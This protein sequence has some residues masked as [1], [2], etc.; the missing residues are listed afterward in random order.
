[1]TVRW[2]LAATEIAPPSPGTAV[3]LLPGP[4][5][6]GRS[7]EAALPTGARI[8]AGFLVAD[9]VTPGGPRVYALTADGAIARVDPPD[10]GDLGHQ[11]RFRPARRVQVT[12]VDEGGTPV[13][14]AVVGLRGGGY[15]EMV[16]PTPTDANGE[17]RFERLFPALLSITLIPPGESSRYARGNEVQSVNLEDGDADVTITHGPPTLERFEFHLH[18]DGRP[19]LPAVLGLSGRGSPKVVEERP[20]GRRARRRLQHARGRHA[21]AR[22]PAPAGLPARHGG[23]ERGGRNGRPQ[24]ARRPRARGAAARAHRRRGRRQR[25]AQ[26]G[27]LRRG[28]TGVAHALRAADPSRPAVPE[29]PARRVRLRRPRSGGVGARS[30]RPPVLCRKRPTS[31]R[32]TSPPS[33]SRSATSSGSA[34]VSSCRTPR[35]CVAC[36]SAPSVSTPRSRCRRVP[37]GTSRGSRYAT[38][39]SGCACPS[40]PRRASA[41]GTPG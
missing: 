8:E 30:T 33:T 28:G 36:A 21:R 5:D 34:V 13:E 41:R 12:V 31:S 29:R 18:I 1:M 25:R 20:G 35:S 14:G 27:A 37:G 7:V 26:A 23:L 3:E 24:G 2:P 6:R 38:T 40:T 4:P 15:Q 22:L 19:A 32:A 17:V 9:D 16:E 11:V 10:E 39:P